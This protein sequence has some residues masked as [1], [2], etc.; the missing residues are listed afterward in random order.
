MTSRMAGPI[1]EFM[2]EP[3]LN[4]ARYAS[5]ALATLLGDAHLHSRPADASI[6]ADRPKKQKHIMD[7]KYLFVSLAI[8]CLIH[9][10]DSSPT[11]LGL[12]F[13]GISGFEHAIIL[14]ESGLS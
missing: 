2:N 11:P 10:P 6:A 1:L 13:I 14:G 4:S 12:Q 9:S 5:T 8:K 7:K 3:A